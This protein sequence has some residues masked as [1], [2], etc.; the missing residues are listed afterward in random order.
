MLGYSD[1]NKDG[2]MLTSTWRFSRPSRFALV[3]EECRV[4]LTLFHGRG[5]LRTRGGPTHHA[6]VS[7]PAGAFS[8][9]LK[10]PSR[11]S[12]ELEVL[13]CCAG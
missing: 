6:I 12:H 5:G 2:G 1:S 10:I 3:A 9:K 7:Q 8:G 4:K 13:R 11:A